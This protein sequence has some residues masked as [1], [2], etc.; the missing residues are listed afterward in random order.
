MQETHY[1]FGLA[2]FPAK[3][4]RCRWER[5]HS[6]LQ[7]LPS[8]TFKGNRRWGYAILYTSCGI[9]DE[10]R[11]WWYPQLNS[12]DRENA[13]RIVLVAWC[14]TTALCVCEAY[15]V[16]S[17][18][19]WCSLIRRLNACKGRFVSDWNKWMD[20]CKCELFYR[21][22]SMERVV[23]NRSR[24]QAPV[25]VV[26]VKSLRVGKSTVVLCTLRRETWKEEREERRKKKRKI[27]WMTRETHICVLKGKEIQV[28]GQVSPREIVEQNGKERVCEKWKVRDWTIGKPLLWMCCEQPCDG[29]WCQSCDKPQN[30]HQPIRKEEWDDQG[31]ESF[32]LWLESK[33][34]GVY[35]D[36]NSD[37]SDSLQTSRSESESTIVTLSV[38]A[39]AELST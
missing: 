1:Q 36:L 11:F 38:V 30:R 19:K 18:R 28:R 21:P 39:S 26:R 16:I 31:S 12:P 2:R 14:T 32:E 10:S 13:K 24:D 9:K 22:M 8:M 15:D 20:P 3:S 7:S 35:L 37:S 5:S 6:V 25:R 29:R 27:V 23:K 4:C 34:E 33:K 17:V